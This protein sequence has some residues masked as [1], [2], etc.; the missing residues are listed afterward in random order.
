MI[1]KTKV[2]QRAKEK[3][4]VNTGTKVS[5]KKETTVHGT[6]LIKTATNT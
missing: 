4:N 2:F 6:T 5:V 1:M 3:L